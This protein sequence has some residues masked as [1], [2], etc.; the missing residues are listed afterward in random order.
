[1][2]ADESLWFIGRSTTN[3]KISWM[4][5][6]EWRSWRE[7]WEMGFA[8]F[9]VGKWHF[10]HCMDPG[11]TNNN[12]NKIQNGDGIWALSYTISLEDLHGIKKCPQKYGGTYTPF[13]WQHLLY[14]HGNCHWPTA[15]LS[16]RRCP[17]SPWFLRRY[18]N[19]IKIFQVFCCFW[20]KILI[21][22]SHITCF[23]TPGCFAC[24]CST[25]L[26]RN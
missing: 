2:I 10:M 12:N 21:F 13:P 19:N 4:S 18:I 9:W 15:F 22:P 5:A 20:A 14:F 17:Q 8:C 24:G 6:A 7:I 3:L 11:S 16:F 25:L 1:M 26:Q 23:T